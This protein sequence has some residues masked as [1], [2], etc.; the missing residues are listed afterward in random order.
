MLAR[1]WTPEELRDPDRLAA[2]GRAELRG[3][4]RRTA[5]EVENASAVAGMAASGLF[6]FRGRVYLGQPVSYLDGVALQEVM[7]QLRA[8]GGAAVSAESL[9]SLRSA[10][11]VAARLFRRN[12][13]PIGW[14]RLFWRI[15]PNPFLRMTEV[16]AGQLLGFFLACRMRSSVRLAYTEGSSTRPT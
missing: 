4:V 13:R 12:A 9:A 2:Q 1:A 3:A 11:A 16:E 10:L 14:R 15:T 5:R 7:L 6:H 8:L